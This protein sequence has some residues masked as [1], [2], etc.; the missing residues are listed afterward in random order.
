MELCGMGLRVVNWRF[1]YDSASKRG[2]TMSIAKCWTEN[3]LTDS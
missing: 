3:F 1:L 2:Y